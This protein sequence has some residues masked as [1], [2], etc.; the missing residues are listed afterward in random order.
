MRAWMRHAR[1]TKRGEFEISDS[2]PHSPR[3]SE[4]A[5][6]ERGLHFAAEHDRRREQLDLQIVRT[7]GRG[8]VRRWLVHP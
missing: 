7:R 1:V 3:M 8:A 4:A 2:S 6:C 5:R